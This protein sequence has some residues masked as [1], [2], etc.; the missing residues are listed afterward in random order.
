MNGEPN[1]VN[2]M[3]ID[4]TKYNDRT[5]Q[6]DRLPTYLPEDLIVQDKI[7]KDTNTSKHEVQKFVTPYLA[8]EVRTL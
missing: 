6:N 3:T 8:I 5:Y 2:V 7:I 4:E 1:I